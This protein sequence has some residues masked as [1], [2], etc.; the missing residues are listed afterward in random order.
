MRNAMVLGTLTSLLICSASHGAR[1]RVDE[2]GG[3]VFGVYL[4]GEELN[5]LFDTVIVNIRPDDGFAFANIDE[6]GADGF[7]PRPAGDPLTYINAFL[8]A[9]STFCCGFSVL[10]PV[11]SS[12][13]ISFTTGPLGQTIDTENGPFIRDNGLFLVNIHLP[14]GTASANA[15]LVRAGTVVAD[16]TMPF[17]VPEPATTAMLACALACV[18]SHRRFCNWTENTHGR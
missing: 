5:G 14:N 13:E 4:D 10:G 6:D 17:G 8:G 11:T 12:T 18:A 2:F 15:L 3:G 1:V 7:T 9:P 16:L